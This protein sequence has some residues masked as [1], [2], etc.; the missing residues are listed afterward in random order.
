MPC[1]ACTR[2]HAHSRKLDPLTTPADFECTYDS[3]EEASEP[4]S[5]KISRLQA[6][7]AE[8]ELIVQAQEA[9]LAACV[10]HAAVGLDPNF[11]TVMD[12]HNMQLD[13]QTSST[14]TPTIIVSPVLPSSQS[15]ETRSGSDF[16]RSPPFPLFDPQ[17][18]SPATSPMPEMKTLSTEIWPINIPPPE[19]LYHLVETVLACV[20]LANRVIHRPTFMASLAKP[21]S[22]L[23]F[24][25]INLLHAICALASLYTPIVTDVNPFDPEAELHE[26]GA[27][28]YSAGVVNRPINYSG[29]RYFP[30][31]REDLA[32]ADDENDFAG[33][34]M[35]WLWTGLKIAIR[36]GDAMLQQ[37]QAEDSSSVYV[38]ACM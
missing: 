17:I 36:H 5:S 38:E 4:P 14:L 34:H 6:R 10:C 8:L 27:A 16:G 24:P 7:I 20:P 9:Q 2:S 31:R 23:D 18:P 15:P 32:D 28:V 22:S 11:E 25:H 30:R 26:G 19:L 1:G 35:R 21:A 3:P 29:R 13:S 37:A 12:S 33:V